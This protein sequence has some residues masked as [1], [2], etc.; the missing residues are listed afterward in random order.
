MNTYKSQTIVDWLEAQGL[1]KEKAQAQI[2]VSNQ[3]EKLPIFVSALMGIGALI[4]SCFLITLISISFIDFNNEVE[5]FSSSI[6]FIVLALICYYTL[7][8]APPL[9]Q[10]LA[11]QSAFIFMVAGKLLFVF[12]FAKLT[13]F[14]L[15][16]L[17][18]VWMVSLGLGIVTLSFYCIFPLLLDRFLFSFLFL[19]S[20]L[21][22]VLN[23][24]TPFLDYFL[25]VYF[26]LL[27]FITFFI[28]MW[29]NKS[30]GWA[31]LAYAL[32]TTLCITALYISS[33]YVNNST[34]H[35]LWR[36]SH[37]L[38]DKFFNLPLGIALILVCLMLAKKS[39]LL[40]LSTICACFGIVLL[41]FTSTP[42][43]LV[44]LGL[45]II[46]TAKY[47]RPLF[48]LGCVFL[49]FFIIDYYYTWQLA[50]NLKSYVLIA[51]GLVMLGGSLIIKRLKWDR[52]PS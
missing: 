27:I 5:V 40:H 10:S 7:R 47:E 3:A 51:T 9:L 31:P 18:E 49:C 35:Y 43:I 38:Y 39:K 50:L 23:E 29:R 17:N 15:L 11:I 12:G 44:S 30:A 34:F 36:L 45:L 22:S 33:V 25:L 32:A 26:I 21:F 6:F 42:G 1:L 46:A 24:S 14:N 4:G 2:L 20:I 19:C 37:Q 8:R 41:T 16:P 52:E 13:K 28:F 48:I